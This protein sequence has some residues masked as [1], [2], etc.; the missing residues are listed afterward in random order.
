MP[1]EK[2]YEPGRKAQGILFPARET[3][4]PVRRRAA[5]C[6]DAHS[7]RIS[8]T[9]VS[10]GDS[11]PLRILGDREI[12]TAQDHTARC[13]EEAL[14]IDKAR[15]RARRL[16]AMTAILAVLTLLPLIIAVYILTMF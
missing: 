15:T 10:E 2:T 14:A 13:L 16:G 1:Q 3:R 4:C 9:A 7:H 6:R 11:F 5:G 12:M 8:Q